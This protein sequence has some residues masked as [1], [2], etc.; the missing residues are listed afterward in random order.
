MHLGDE[1]KALE[2]RKESLEIKKNVL[3]NCA[4]H[5]EIVTSLNALGLSSLKLGFETQAVNLFTEALE[6][7]KRIYCLLFC[8][9]LL[10]FREL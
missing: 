8:V 5:V 3:E 10:L 1:Y 6:I 2:L 7:N 4:D 9:I